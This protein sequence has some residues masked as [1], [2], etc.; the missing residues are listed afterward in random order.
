MQNIKIRTCCQKYCSN[1]F[2]CGP[3]CFARLMHPLSII[4]L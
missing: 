4:N 3:I 1:C 2:C